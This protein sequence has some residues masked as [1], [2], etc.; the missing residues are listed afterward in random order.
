MKIIRITFYK[1]KMMLADRL[2]FIAMIVLPLILAAVVGYALRIEKLNTIPVAVVDEDNS[3][4]SQL[5]LKRLSEKDR[6]EVIATNRPDALKMLEKNRLEQVFIIKEGFEERIIEG[7]SSRII[8]F[9]KA[10]SSY[11]SEYVGEVFAGEVIRLVTNNSAANWVMD[12]YMELDIPVDGKLREEVAGFADSQWEP[13][14]L[15]TVDYIETG[16]MEEMDG[17]VGFMSVSASTTGIMVFFIM[18]YILF[19]SGWL[20][21]ERIN[22]TL[23]R[24]AAGSDALFYSFCGSVAAM[25][26]SAL[27]QVALFCL[28]TRLV[29]GVPLFAHGLSYLLIIVYILSVVSICMFLSSILRTPAQL[30]AC[31]PAFTLLTGFLGGCFWNIGQ[32]PGKL[33]LLSRLTPQGWTLEGINNLA[34]Y[35]GD[36]GVILLPLLVLFTISLILLPLSYIIMYNGVYK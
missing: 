2:F 22:G 18:L 30:Q 21:E 27:L 5:L 4:Y 20:V 3:S 14:P 7:N 15:M 29:F 32:L 6:L 23:R 9:L 13:E 35:V 10:P 24:L 19:S 34:V 31:A 1:L 36:A 17:N 28:I 12:K 25:V 33:K 26:V 8:D 11:T 16:S